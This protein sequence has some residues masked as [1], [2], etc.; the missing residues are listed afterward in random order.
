MQKKKLNIICYDKFFFL[1]LIKQKK[2]R[3]INNNSINDI[4][5]VYKDILFK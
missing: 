3:W 4:S 2:K 1:I 5:N